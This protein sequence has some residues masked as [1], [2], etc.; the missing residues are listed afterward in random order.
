MQIMYPNSTFEMIPIIVCCLGYVQN[1][2]KTYMKQ[3]GFDDKEISFLVLR[4]HSLLIFGTVNICKAYF[5]FND[6]K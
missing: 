2:F 4:L 5:Y 1:D 3:L 6:A